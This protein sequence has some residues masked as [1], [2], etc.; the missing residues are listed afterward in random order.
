[1]VTRLLRMASLATTTAC[2]FFFA[3][4]AVHA[5]RNNASGAVL[6]I[7]AG[8]SIYES[9]LP[10]SVQTQ[11]QQFRFGEFQVK[12]RALNEIID[13]YFL[14][15]EAKKRGT[16]GEKLLAD[17]VDSRLPSPTEA[18]LEAAYASESTKTKKPFSEAKVEIEQSLRAER[19]REA[20]SAYIS[21]LRVESQ[22]DFLLAPPMAEIPYDPGRVRGDPKASVLIVEFGDFQC[23]FSREI[24]PTLKDIL[25]KY[26][27]QVRLA[28]RD[29]PLRD[30]HPLAET[31][32]AAARCAGQQGKFWEYHDMVF[33]NQSKLDRLS[34]TEVARSLR[35]DERRFDSCLSGGE[36]KEQVQQDLQGGLDLGV[37]GTPG[38]FIN[39]TYFQGVL[40]P[41]VL[42]QIIEDELAPGRQK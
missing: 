21:Q 27:G 34:L 40:P 17:A 41:G 29:F 7:V 39:G 24:E 5:T 35:L 33:E 25:S 20:R 30:I 19:V 12:K 42:D 28:F 10:P 11:L 14:D 4:Y 8:H 32:A 31:A 36:Y 38:I 2:L 3:G 23:P 1:M 37:T 22:V 13:R 16:S 15:E 9:D 26:Q 6:A 18:E